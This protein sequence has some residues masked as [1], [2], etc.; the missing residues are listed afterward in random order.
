[1]ASELPL[2]EEFMICMAY[3]EAAESQLLFKK[4]KINRAVA[5]VNSGVLGVNR[6]G[7]IS[8]HQQTASASGSEMWEP[9]RPPFL[10]L[11]G[12]R[13]ALLPNNTAWALACF[14]GPWCN[15]EGIG[16]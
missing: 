11:W 3:V 12:E 13:V 5:L 10:K 4:K 2:A 7:N 15:G 1:M 8:P 9:P 16:S 6:C 14:P